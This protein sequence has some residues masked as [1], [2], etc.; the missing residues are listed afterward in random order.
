VTAVSATDYYPELFELDTNYH[1][2]LLGGWQNESYLT[3]VEGELFD[4]FVFAKETEPTNLELI[5]EIGEANSVS[6][7]SREGDY[8]T[9]GFPVCGAEYY[10]RAMA[11]IEARIDHPRYFVF[12]DNV[13]YAKSVI[14]EKENIRYITHNHGEK[15]YRDMQLMSLCKHN[16]IA[17]SSFS[18]WGA[19][20]NKNKNKLV[21]VPNKPVGSCRIPVAC[22]AWF[23]LDERKPDAMQK[24]QQEQV[25]ELLRTLKEAHDELQKQSASDAVTNLLADCQDFAMQIKEYIESV[26]GEGTKTV[27]LLDDYYEIAY[28]ISKCDS[29][30]S[31]QI[32]KLVEQLA[33]IENSV[34]TEFAPDVNKIIIDQF[35][36]YQEKNTDSNFRINPD[37]LAIFA[38]DMFDSAGKSFND[39]YLLQDLWGAQK[40]YERKPA[41][42]YDIGSRTDGFI[43]H[44]LSF[45]QK[46]VLI[47]IRP[48]ETYNVENL[49]FICSD[50]TNLSEFEDESVESLSAL[51]SL[52]HFG[53]GRYGDPV[54]P[55]AHIKVFSSIQRIMKP[56]GNAYI[57]VP[58]AAFPSLV[59]NAHRIYT[60][61]LVCSYFSRMELVEFSHTSPQG[62]VKNVSI[63]EFMGYASGIGLYRDDFYGLFHFKKSDLL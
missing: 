37:Y 13:Q 21:V 43:T 62:L 23:L 44:I 48:L 35:Y 52:E 27:S 33:N 46:V 29:L 7:H 54:D 45:R 20:L 2:Y 55:E 51:C 26:V 36:E 39:S 24:D 58:V 12:A 50:A 40:V 18:F 17:N 47:D 60:P 5:K 19:Y 49:T 28:H 30:A 10:Q 25:L 9:A 6:I 16:I 41:I 14:G 32:C 57:A 53:L 59:F 3:K 22:K 38:A 56:K 4:S 15:S 1:Y 8:I 63:S 42:H 61:E 11:Y 31:D 34:L